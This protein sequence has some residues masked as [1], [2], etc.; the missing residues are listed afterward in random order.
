MVD[1]CCSVRAKL[2]DIFGQNPAV[3][4]DLFHAIQKIIVQIPKRQAN[5]ALRKT[6]RV[7]IKE[8]RLCFRAHDDI[9]QIRKQATPSSEELE[10]NLCSFLKR[11]Q[12]EKIEGVCVLP[13]SAVDEVEKLHKHVRSGCLSGIPVGIGTN[14]NERLHRKLRK[15][16]DKNRMGVSYAVA[17][18]FLIFYNHM[19]QNKNC[20]NG[21]REEKGTLYLLLL[22][23]TNHF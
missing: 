19:E 10:N 21:Q 9:G 3:K 22:N 8:L 18:L 4:L 16:V 2:R 17:V 6:Q 11:W 23:G 13:K 5:P 1:N 7:M 20:R 15:W 14:R 12:A